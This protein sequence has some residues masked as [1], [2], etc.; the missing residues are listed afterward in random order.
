MSMFD[1]IGCSADPV[2]YGFDRFYSIAEAK[3]KVVECENLEA[4]AEHKNRKILISLRDYAFDEGAIKL[5][6]EKKS[7]CFLID[8]GKLMR[9][10]GVPRAIAFSKLRNFLRLCVKHGAL[11]TFATFAENE[12]R[13]RSAEELISI[14]TLFDLN[15]GQAKF[16]LKMLKHY[17]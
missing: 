15:R 7:A 8:I 10:R 11:Y 5:I 17:L 4:A 2:A 1:I 13:I 14:I 16:A 9:V 6:A 3:G 12:P